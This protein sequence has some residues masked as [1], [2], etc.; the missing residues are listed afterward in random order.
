MIAIPFG[1]LVLGFLVVYALLLV[2]NAVSMIVSVVKR[3]RPRHSRS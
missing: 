1:A 3:K 2:V